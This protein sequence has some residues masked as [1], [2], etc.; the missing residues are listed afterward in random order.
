MHR[1][2]WTPGRHDRERIIES[3]LSYS[4]TGCN[5]PNSLSAFLKPLK[6][7]SSD[8]VQHFSDLESLERSIWSDAVE[9]AFILLHA[10][11]EFT[12]YAPHD[13]TAGFCFHLIEVLKQ[14]KEFFIS[15]IIS[16]DKDANRMEYVRKSLEVPVTEFATECLTKL[17]QTSD[18]SL[19]ETYRE[20]FHEHFLRILRYWSENQH[21]AD[22]SN[23]T[24]VER[25]VFRLMSNLEFVK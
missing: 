22:Y 25:E 4:R 8:F 15:L 2:D 17:F 11:P 6:L 9:V 20:M 14:N 5:P 1:L 24:L 7:S 3:F 12:H 16:L 18:A 13:K 23:D 19:L 10:D 21:Y